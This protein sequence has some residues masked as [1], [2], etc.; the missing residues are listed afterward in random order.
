MKIYFRRICASMLILSMLFPVT[1]ASSDNSV[2]KIVTIGINE[3][4]IGDEAPVIRIENYDNDF[5]DSETIVLKLENAHWLDDEDFESGTFEENMNRDSYITKWGEET[6]GSSVYIEKKNETTIHAKVHNVGKENQ[7][8]IPLYSKPL[9]E[10]DMIVI[11][12]SKS[13]VITQESITYARVSKEGTIIS[14]DDMG[15]FK[16]KAIFNIYPIEIEEVASGSFP[17]KE[18]TIKI[19]LKEGFK[20]VEPGYID[21]DD[22]I[23]KKEV[24]I[25]DDNTLNIV[26]DFSKKVN[27]YICGNVELKNAKIEATDEINNYEEQTVVLEI[28]SE[29]IDAIDITSI[30]GAHHTKD[31]MIYHLDSEKDFLVEQ[32]VDQVDISFN[33]LQ[34]KNDYTVVDLL[35]GQGDYNWIV[36]EESRFEKAYDFP[37]M[38]KKY[39]INNGK[40]IIDKALKKGKYV[41][42]SPELM[43]RLVCDKVSKDDLKLK[44]QLNEDTK[45][46]KPVAPT[47]PEIMIPDIRVDKQVNITVSTKLVEP[48]APKLIIKNEYGDFDDEETIVLKLANSEWLE[49]DDFKHG[50][51]EESINRDS[52]IYNNIEDSSVDIEKISNTKIKVKVK[53]LEYKGMLMIP[54]YSKALEQGEMTVEVDVRSGSSGTLRYANACNE[55]TTITIANIADFK[56]KDICNVY[57]IEIEEV[58]IGSFPD[59]EGIIEIKLEE[60]FKWVEP[61]YIHLWEFYAEEEVRIIDDRTLNIV[62]DFPKEI[63][64]SYLHGILLKDA[65]IQAL[66]QVNNYEKKIA[67]ITIS[68]DNI[69]A[70]ENTTLQVAKHEKDKMIYNFQKDFSV[71]QKTDEI[72]IN[73]KK[74]QLKNDYTVTD[75]VYGKVNYNWVVVEESNFEEV[76]N[77]SNSQQ[78]YKINNG[79]IIIDRPLKKGSYVLFSPELMSSLVCKKINKDD[80]K[81]KFQL[82]KDTIESGS[83]GSSGGSSSGGS[84]G[85]GGGGSSKPKVNISEKR[86]KASAKID[87]KNMDTFIKKAK[88]DSY[89]NVPITTNEEKVELILDS[90]IL[91]KVEKEIRMEN[92]DLVMVLK[93]DVLDNLKKHNKN[94]SMEINK[95]TMSE[96]MNTL[97]GSKYSK[98]Y[99]QVFKVN[100]SEDIGRIPVI[101]NTKIQNKKMTNVFVLGKDK[102]LHFVPSTVE[103]NSIKFEADKDKEYV[104]IEKNISFN[105]LNS[106]W[107]RDAVESLASKNIIS[108]FQN[109]EFKPD[110]NL[111]RAQMATILVKALGLDTFN[112]DNDK[113]FEDMDTTNWASEY[114]YLAKENGLINGVGNNKFNPNGNITGE[115]LIQLAINAYENNNEK[116]EVTKEEIEKISGS[117]DWAKV[118]IAKAKKLGLE[119][120]ILEQLSYKG[121]GK[122]SQAAGI[123]SELIKD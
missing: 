48:L 34:L 36:T 78:K 13:W 18:G 38:E 110:D 43:E 75:L 88:D 5:D 11:T 65:K 74:L 82:D 40:L 90:D 104:I 10:G 45:S 118:A 26:V 93:K 68:S 123:I 80:L 120:N 21:T 60:G 44:I 29:N 89:I 85:G 2:N 98:I 86:N 79:K 23:G 41:I 53:N 35:D 17:N 14:I 112:E 92:K 7:V 113:V 77:A 119:D 6:V 8:R 37:E 83:S 72:Q 31:K 114:V 87:K 91:K 73:L 81:L 59:K 107:A 69:N 47:E 16:D 58:A 105:D 106:H 3:K 71:E 57:P 70:I 49:D 28:S 51:F 42:F 64:N 1:Y 95:K 63:N 46:N 9:D 108:G 111:N 20:W 115:Q 19:K 122:R 22:F 62:V 12:D 30:W 54:L 117:S 67:Q 102:K 56:D 33:K 109:G 100:A 50:T 66:D 99:T 103:E 55:E 121:N 27:K 116:I 97:K 25:V 15:T 32:K 52:Y 76:Y 39:K 4:L 94:I 61:G 101:Y 84:S 96:T 24:N